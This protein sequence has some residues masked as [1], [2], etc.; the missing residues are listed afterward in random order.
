MKTF[1]IEPNRYL[2]QPVTGYF[3]THYI[4][5]GY[6]NNPDYIN[7]LKNDLLHADA[8]TLSS[9]AKIV[10]DILANDLPSIIEKKSIHRPVVCVMP[11]AKQ[12]SYYDDSQLMFQSAVSQ[13]VDNIHGIKNGT[14]WITRLKATKTT[15][16]RG[17]EWYRDPSNLSP[18]QGITN[19]T[20]IISPKVKGRNIILVDDVYTADVNVIEDTLQALIDKGAKSVTSY[21]LSKTIRR[22]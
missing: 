8:L 15:H 22:H 18:Y 6:E 9:D 13:S 7:R 5:M 20:C 11:R 16:L 21:V 3:H 4:K 1:N 10:M 19:D 12:T 2:K 14:T 17:A